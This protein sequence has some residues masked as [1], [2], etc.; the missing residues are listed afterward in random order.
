MAVINQLSVDL[1]KDINFLP[2]CITFLIPLYLSSKPWLYNFSCQCILV[3]RCN[4]VLWLLSLSSFLTLTGTKWPKLCCC[5]IKNVLTHSL[6]QLSLLLVI[7]TTV[8]S[9]HSVV[10]L[11]FLR[12]GWMKWGSGEVVFRNRA[13]QR[14]VT[15]GSW[16]TTSK[17][18]F[19]NVGC[20]L[21]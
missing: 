14:E 11:E 3:N 16:K 18:K 12:T 4:F 7:V 8:D 13:P 19:R 17:N 10:S 5:A 15:W 2:L 21:A 20:I 1:I 6:W 9:S